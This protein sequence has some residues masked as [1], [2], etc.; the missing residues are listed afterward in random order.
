M[1]NLETWREWL[2]L[3]CN[4]REG[5]ARRRRSRRMKI[6]VL[7]WFQQPRWPLIEVAGWSP[8]PCHRGPNHLPMFP[9]KSPVYDRYPSYPKVPADKARLAAH[10]RHPARRVPKYPIPPTPY[11]RSFTDTT[12]RSPPAPTAISNLKPLCR[13]LRMPPAPSIPLALAEEARQL[14]RRPLRSSPSPCPDPLP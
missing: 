7:G 1:R 6:R 10:R 5:L 9:P 8:P 13:R 12:F 4:G 3:L 11:P 14:L 2:Q